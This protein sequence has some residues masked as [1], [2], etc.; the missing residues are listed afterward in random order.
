LAA[1]DE[2]SRQLLL[3]P[4][5]D[6]RVIEHVLATVSAVVAAADITV[7]VAQDDQSVRQQ[8]GPNFDYAA[9]PRPLG[10]ANA[11]RTGLARIF[12]ANPFIGTEASGETR[13]T[14][15]GVGGQ[16]GG[17]EEAAP[18]GADVERRTGGDGIGQ[19]VADE[20]LAP[21][22]SGEPVTGTEAGGREAGKPGADVGDRAEAD[23]IGQNV[24]DE[25]LAPI[26]SG[27]PVTGT[28]AGGREAGKPGADVGERAGGDG[29]GQGVAD[30]TLV[31]V[32]SGDLP[33]LR[34]ASLRGLMTRHRLKRADLSRL[35]LGDRDVGVYVAGAGTWARLLN[36]AEAGDLEGRGSLRRLAERAGL[37]LATSEYQII[38]PDELHDINT[39]QDLA[40][41]AEIL[42]KRLFAPQHAVESGAIN[43]G[44]GGWRAKIGE[45]FT[46]HNVRRLSQ[47]LAAQVIEAGQESKGVVIGG[48]RRFLSREAAEAAAEVF[49]GNNIKVAL[50]GEDVPTPL[51]TFAA[52]HLGAHYGLVFTASHN[53]PQ[54][55]GLKVFRADGS[56]PLK[57]ETDRYETE[58][59]ALTRADIVATDL[60]AARRA[61]WVENRDLT[62]PY[63]D[64]IERI[65]DIGVIRANPQRV[66]VDPMY[67]TSQ[68][69][70]GTILTDAR[71]RVDFIH[72]R[73]N[74]LFGGRS[75]APDQAALTALID[76]VRT[77]PYDLGLATDGDA[78]RIA[79][80]DQDGR[81]I[82]TND[83]LLLLYWYLHEV[84]GERGG[85]V[86][87]IATTHLLD[88][89]A[90]HFGET[91]REA[92][93]GFKHI[94]QGMS[95][96]AA[97]LGGESS[98]G[99]TIRGH[100]LGKDG[101]FA[102]ALVVEMLAGTGLALSELLEKV[103][104]ITGRLYSFETGLPATPDMRLAVP[105][106]LASAV[107]LAL[108]GLPLQRL[109]QSDGFK[110]YLDGDAWGLARF[111][112]TEPVLRVF[113]EAAS[114]E[115]AQQIAADLIQLTRGS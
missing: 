39:D 86:R 115:L 6:Q 24:A 67:G 15:S 107:P 72:E 20:T 110:F 10:P 27:E 59:N 83:L 88:R 49:A 38:D 31:L 99:L 23:G 97:L 71:C 17:G 11:V 58:A 106:R 22:M 14:A 103:Y 57:A 93:V 73:H 112:G 111:S 9:Q 78:D 32:V 60:D 40:T 52:P 45:G 74:P 42:L 1:G 80:V 87:N 108:A 8:L 43:F 41:A 61:G 81:Y 5:G 28:E 92:P 2:Q 101:I 56:L 29:I 96:S 100:I 35:M 70:L 102:C 21:I 13:P 47:A 34:P 37:T 50:L 7:V 76:L 95:D 18:T 12:P 62:G 94:T 105:R 65:V 55:N 85:V 68:L 104:A 109:D 66:L 4:L 89:L 46:I 84:R 36:Q 79:I 53:P 69:T 91:A 44:T 25:T 64:A 63:I 26:M 90:A 114:P 19:D 98:G 16:P 48:D 30:E 77:G 113:A 75:P 82:S 3:R 33:L 54:W 51:V